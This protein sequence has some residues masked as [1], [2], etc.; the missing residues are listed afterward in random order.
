[1][2]AGTAT[3]SEENKEQV[4]IKREIEPFEDKAFSN[5]V[6]FSD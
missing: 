5:S 1:M 6:I 3:G 4:L 2:S